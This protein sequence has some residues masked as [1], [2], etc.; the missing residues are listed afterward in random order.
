MIQQR[1]TNSYDVKGSRT[2]AAEAINT[3][4][5]DTLHVIFSMLS[6]AK[7]QSVKRVSK[8]WANCCRRTILSSMWQSAETNLIALNSALP[9]FCVYE[10]AKSAFECLNGSAKVKKMLLRKK[11]KQMADIHNIRLIGSRGEDVV[12]ELFT[13]TKLFNILKGP[14]KVIQAKDSNNILIFADVDL[15]CGMK[16]LIEFADKCNANGMDVSTFELVYNSTNN[17][18]IM[19]E[20]PF[21]IPDSV[22][23]IAVGYQFLTKAKITGIMV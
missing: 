22:E 19:S 2:A 7:L 11:C 15:D 3:L 8:T 5:M 13:M 4:H 6:L 9:R 23:M 1:I 21:F 16:E 17:A 12:E 18:Y 14:F 20:Y 10:S